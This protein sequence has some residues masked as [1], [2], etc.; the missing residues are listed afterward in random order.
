M[1]TIT[2]ILHGMRGMLLH[3]KQTGKELADDTRLKPVATFIIA[4][5]LL[6]SLMFL[7]SH[8]K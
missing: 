8:L 7:V 2:S 5:G 4:F 3:P 1:R 6:L